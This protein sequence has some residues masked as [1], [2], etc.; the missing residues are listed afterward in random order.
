MQKYP[1]QYKVPG[2]DFAT[3]RPATG[4]THAITVRVSQEAA[5]ILKGAGN[6][7]QL[8]DQLIKDY[9]HESVDR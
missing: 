5:D 3:G 1:T 4:R 8:V 6:K 7:S 2:S 9:H